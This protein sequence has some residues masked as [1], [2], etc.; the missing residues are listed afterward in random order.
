[1]D[2]KII[3]GIETH[4]QLKT[5][6]KMFCSCSTEYFGGKP[7]INV[8]PV[9][10]GYPGAL[11]KVNEDAIK[12]AIKVGKL[13]HF[14]HINYY[15]SFERKNYMYPDLFK[16]FQIT[17]YKNPIVS[18]GYLE[19]D[20]QGEVDPASKDTNHPKATP[21]HHVVPKKINIYRAHLEEDTAKSLHESGY[22]LI[23][24]NKAGIPLLEIVSAPDIN[25]AA[26]AKEYAV[27]LYNI[28]KYSNVSDCDMEK[29]QMRFD[30]NINLEINDSGRKYYTPIV[31]IK[32]LNS[33]RALERSINFEE[34]LQFSEFE[35]NR[36]EM[37]KGN[38]VTK[39]W[40]DLKG[41]TVFQRGKEE[42][43]DYRYFPEPDLPPLVISQ[44]FID[45][46]KI[47]NS[48]ED[49]MLQLEK[50][51]ISKSSAAVLVLTLGIEFVK[52]FNNA[53]DIYNGDLNNLVNWII[54][55]LAGIISEHNIDLSSISVSGFVKILNLVNDKKL[56]ATSAK[57]IINKMIVEKENI[58]E[59]ISSRIV[60][61][62]DT[63]I[64]KYIDAML[65]ENQELVQTYLNGK[66]G[67][68]SFFIGQ[69][70]KKMQGRASPSDIKDKILIKIKNFQ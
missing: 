57:E 40:N 51:N 13:L 36:I 30:I 43:D 70:M 24:G 32:N 46:V 33:F 64:D 17:Q 35:K 2:K 21:T 6:S 19:I 54:N 61:S 11:P 65:G 53:C 8:C 38:K 63:L 1:M 69:V 29:G 60:V 20:T 50:A 25:G 7:N 4:V 12:Q 10:L 14:K 68:L 55:D 28:L 22:T 16:G 5:K 42:S 23:D 39:G 15:S 48:A 62:D 67:V 59:L 45:S 47:E 44:E 3:V 56:T 58:D 26:E 18:D 41:E 27:S 49:T 31:E 34:S 66:E 9:C 37:N 52:F